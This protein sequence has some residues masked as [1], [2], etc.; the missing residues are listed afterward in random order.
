[1][2]YDSVLAYIIT[3]GFSLNRKEAGINTFFVEDTFLGNI[4]RE[5]ILKSFALF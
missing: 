2:Y 1:L 3:V 5:Q 4:K